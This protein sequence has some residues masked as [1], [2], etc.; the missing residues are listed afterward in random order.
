M[1]SEVWEKGMG[2]GKKPVEVLLQYRVGVGWM[3]DMNRG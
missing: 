3:G 2:W 1:K